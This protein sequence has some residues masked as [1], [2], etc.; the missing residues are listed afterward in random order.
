VTLGTLGTTSAAL[1]ES[2][3][4]R[5]GTATVTNLTMTTAGN[6]AD[7]DNTGV[8]TAGAATV[9]S[10]TG[11]LATIVSRNAITTNTLVMSTD[12]VGSTINHGAAGLGEN[13]TAT[14]S[15]NISTV[16]ADSTIEVYGN[17]SGGAFTLSSTAGLRRTAW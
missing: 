2:D 9:M 8:I 3:I 14:T 17:L 15:A 16:V 1:N 11:D 13:I 4:V 10:T 6:N 7:I 12:G 5:S